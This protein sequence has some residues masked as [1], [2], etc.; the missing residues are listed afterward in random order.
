MLNML[1]HLELQVIPSLLGQTA[2]SS[3]TGPD[4][5]SFISV[6]DPSKAQD[7]HPK[8]LSGQ[9]RGCNL[10]QSRLVP[11]GILAEVQSY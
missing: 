10:T 8:A 9:I 1:Y 4:Q 5:F 2:G 6:E 3:E 7:K 11:G